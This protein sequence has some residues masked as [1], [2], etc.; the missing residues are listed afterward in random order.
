VAL[1]APTTWQSAFDARTDIA[2]YGD[3]GLGLFSLALKYAVEDVASIAADSITDGSDDKKCDLIYVDLDEKRAVVAQCYA[4]KEWK[5]EAP[6]GKASDL[7]TAVAWL[8]QRPLSQLP[9]RIVSQAQQ[10]R[11]AVEQSIITELVIWYVHN[12]G[13][14]SNV[15]NEL[16][17]VEHSARS[18]LDK[19]FGEKGR[20]V[21]V[22]A[23]EIGSGQFEK[24]Y[25][26][27][28]S[29]ILVDDR[30]EVRVDNGYIENGPDWSAFVTSISGQ[31]VYRWYKKYNLD[32]FS[33][34]VRD[35]L[36]SRQTDSNINHGIKKTAE[37]GA[38][39]FWVFNNGMTI[40][41]SDFNVS[42][43]K[44]GKGFD[45][46]VEGLSVVNGAQTTG[47]IGTLKRLPS[48][49]LRIPARFVRTANADK[50]QEIIRFNN[51]QNK[52]NASDFRSTDK[53]Q[54]R[55][56]QE[57]DGIPEA[58]YEGGRRGGHSDVIR[59]RQYLLPS[60][61]VGQALA[62]FH[63]DPLVAYNYKQQIWIDDRYYSKYFNDSTT[64]SHLVFVYSL[65]RSVEAKKVDLI[66]K[67]RKGS[68]HLTESEQKQLAFFRAR[69]AI[70]LYV[71]AV[72]SCLE[73]VLSRRV[74]NRFR[75][76]F[77]GSQSPRAGA[78][79]WAPMVETLL[80]FA[81]HLESALSDGL[82]SSER[83]NSAV[84]VFQSLVEATRTPNKSVYDAFAKKLN[85]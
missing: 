59:R 9:A 39:N 11:D 43:R 50:V 41:C 78:A 17:T 47:A 69:G 33:A 12:C 84:K 5:P 58:E 72:S 53:V 38:N 40:L 51:S 75:L 26:D 37:H 55:I 23:E 61:T 20:L 73:S 64:A 68:S 19:H 70:P 76:S 8:L 28:Q 85:Y 45:F 25:R 6:A 36:G 79:L 2:P 35:Y 13:E 15:D 66:Q 60:Y 63:G 7:N 52:I 22:V 74:A 62:A 56:K 24:L 82:K 1:S 54:K 81:S 21:R 67:S 32:L 27:S 29:P 30:I 16:K 44:G 46:I 71:H 83:I 31:M 65:L 4:A 48:K 57:F 10:L 14:S 42:P 77:K 49:D 34:N 18:M 3:V 80:P